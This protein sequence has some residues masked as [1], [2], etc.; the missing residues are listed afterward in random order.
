MI[1]GL[2]FLYIRAVL[3]SIVSPNLNAVVTERLEFAL[4][5]RK[6]DCDSFVLFFFRVYFL[7]FG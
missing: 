6:M 3:T 7:V 4:W 1:H 2:H 5:E